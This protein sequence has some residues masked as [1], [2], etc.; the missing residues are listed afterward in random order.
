MNFLLSFRACF[1]LGL[2]LLFDLRP[3][4]DLRI[5]SCLR[6][7]TLFSFGSQP[8]FRLFQGRRIGIRVFFRFIFGRFDSL[9]GFRFDPG[10]QSRFGPEL[11]FGFDPGLCFFPDSSLGLAPG[12]G[13]G[14]GF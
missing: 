10:S 4:L 2:E 13:F 11:L 5:G 7:N 6:F 8:F 9:G 3:G 14:L 1:G 12:F